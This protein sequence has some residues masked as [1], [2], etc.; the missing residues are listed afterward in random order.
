M[1]GSWH[2]MGYKFPENKKII[3]QYFLATDMSFQQSPLT[4]YMLIQIEFGL[5]QIK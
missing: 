5:V 3:L 4:Q 1:A 2:A